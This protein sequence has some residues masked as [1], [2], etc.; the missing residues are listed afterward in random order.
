MTQEAVVKQAK[1]EI[2]T[3]L[4][5]IK[6]PG[7]NNVIRY[8]QD[9]TFFRAQCHSHHKFT[10]GL[11]V[12]SLG[13]YKEIKKLNTGLPEDSIRVVSLLHDIC[14]SH[15]PDYDDILPRHHCSRSVAM[16]E[17]MKFKFHTGE[18]Y[19]IEKHLYR[20]NIIP[21]AKVY[22]VRNSLRHYLY[23]CDHRDCT[24]YPEG[25]DSYTL[26]EKKHRWYKIDTLLYGTHRPGIEIV[27]DQL[28]RKD[29]MGK[30]DVFFRAPA[31]V[32]YHNN[33]I[34]GL[35]RHSLEVYQEAKAMFDALLKSGQK[36]SFDIDS[37]ILCSLLHD[38]CKMDE[39]VMNAKARPDHTK[40]YN[41]DNPHG[42]KSDRCLR[43]WHLNL[44]DEERQAIIWHMGDH[45]KDAMAEYN[46]T[47]KAVAAGSKLVELIHNADSIAAK[48]ALKNIP[49][50]KL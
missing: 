15:H 42:M 25:F 37:I 20:I 47:Y 45:A 38:V 19:A 9:S 14:T 28:H 4:R 23:S 22:D 16:L 24:T 18:Y 29:C 48:K 43:R 31:S 50:N 7:I 2:L 39:Y 13:V 26:D 36:L 6:R 41:H 1:D 27:I 33:S 17:A 12:H 46:T 40:Q 30:H 21:S 11:A 35:A 3:L 32:S 34:G 49:Q 44:N 8:L 10:G 5:E